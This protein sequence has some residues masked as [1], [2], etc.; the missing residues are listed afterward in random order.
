MRAAGGGET[1]AR[2]EAAHRGGAQ[3][4]HS[5]WFRGRGPGDRVGGRYAASRGVRETRARPEAAHPGAARSAAILL[6]SGGGVSAMGW[7]ATGRRRD[8][9]AGGRARR[10]RR[11]APPLNWRSACLQCCGPMLTWGLQAM[12]ICIAFRRARS[13]SAERTLD[14]SPS[15][16]AICARERLMSAPPGTHQATKQRIGVR[17]AGFAP[18]IC[19]LALSMLQ[20]TE[21]L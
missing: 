15:L 3:R 1:R 5:F 10:G 18:R 2:P 17:R 7:H 21:A 13:P 6:D 8:R 19:I 11:L 20:G 16:Y 4:R 12:S 9:A 14:L